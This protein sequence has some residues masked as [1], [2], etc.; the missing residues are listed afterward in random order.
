[1]TEAY[2]K[3]IAASENIAVGQVFLY[4][5]PNMAIPSRSACDPQVERARFTQACDGARRELENLEKQ[6]A[7]RTQNED[8]AAIFSAHQMMLDD[9]L[10]SEKVETQIDSGI[11]VEKA[12][13][14]ATSELSE[15]LAAMGDELFAARAVDIRDVGRR[16]IRILLGLPDTALDSMQAPAVIVAEDLTPSDTANLN[17]ELALGICTAMGGLT[18][19]SAILARTLGL[20][21]IVG[22]GLEAFRSINQGNRVI[23]DGFTGILTINPEDETVQKVLQKKQRYQE[24]MQSIIISAKHPGCTADGRRVEV[25]ANIGD[26]ESAREA[27]EFGAEGVGLLR[28]EFLYLNDVHAPNEEKQT[29]IY[30]DIFDIMGTLPVVIRTMDIGGDKPPSYLPFPQEM[31]PFLGW[32]AIRMCLENEDIFKTQ[33]RAILRAANGH[34]IRI[35]FPMV[36]SVEELRCAREMLDTAAAELKQE[37]REFAEKVQIGIMVE[38]PAAAVLVDQLA[39]LSDF[40]SLGTNDLTQYTLA[41]DRGNEKVA[42]LYQPLH[43]AVL[44]LINLTI[45]E[46]HKKGKW[47]G[48]CGELAGMPKAIPIL[49]GMGLDEF[50]MNSRAI[51]AAKQLMRKITDLDA[52]VISE[53]AL[54][55]ATSA[56]VESYMDG[57]LTS[58]EAKPSA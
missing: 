12:V 25:V 28:T 52:Q 22:I 58:L 51:P 4:S 30:S 5:A 14:E 9:P 48:M 20:P 35:M 41:V 15:M 37:G 8:L 43:P 7:V 19:H 53:H 36:I 13:S 23:V 40:F 10:F 29:K 39:G 16:V 34:D 1:M 33:L 42:N 56:E 21:A 55:L 46:A 26:L 3:G 24:E 27:L 50:S 38:T 47:V 45:S 49:L 18:S 57:I 11:N 17:P 44:R 31:N 32:R 2:I 6:V 54:S